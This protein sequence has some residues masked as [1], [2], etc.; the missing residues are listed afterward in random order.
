MEVA[1]ASASEA[2]PEDRRS[3][4]KQRRLARL[5]AVYGVLQ[6]LAAVDVSAVKTKAALH[7]AIVRAMAPVFLDPAF[8]QSEIRE[9]PV[10]WPPFIDDPGT[11]LH[12]RGF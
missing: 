5:R 10:E 7:L 12:H 6:L 11:G 4:P 8:P 1:L 2:V 9:L 3:T